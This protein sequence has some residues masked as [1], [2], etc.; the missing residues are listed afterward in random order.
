MTN[1][2][3]F[4]RSPKSRIRPEPWDGDGIEPEAEEVEPGE[5]GYDEAGATDRELVDADRSD[6][7]LN[8]CMGGVPPPKSDKSR[9]RVRWPKGEFPLEPKPEVLEPGDEG[10]EEAGD[11]DA[12][13]PVP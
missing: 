10:Y 7:A 12:D 2:P 13:L 8:W 11:S 9:I 5:P 3:P 6:V 1:D 4:P